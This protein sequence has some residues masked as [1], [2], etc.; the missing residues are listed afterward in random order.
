[1]QAELV[2]QHGQAKLIQSLYLKPNARNKWVFEI[3]DEDIE[4]S[5]DWYAE[6]ER[7]AAAHP[8]TKPDAA[9]S[10]M[11]ARFNQILGD[12]AIERPSASIGDDHQ[13]L[14]EAYEHRL[15]GR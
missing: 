6:E 3:N 2:I 10:P 11:Q 1:M 14:M 7:A 15:D 5:R 4:P 12:L 13:T 8:A 9:N